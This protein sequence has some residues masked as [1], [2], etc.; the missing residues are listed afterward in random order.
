MSKPSA[1]AALK[2]LT[3]A[4]IDQSQLSAIFSAVNE[5][6]DRSAAIVWAAMVDDAL[7]AAIKRKMRPLSSTDED[8]LFDGQ[9]ALST[10]SS[11]I[12]VAYALCAIGQEQ[13]NGLERIRDIRNA[14]AH[15]PYISFKTKQIFD[16]A[17]LL[18][19]Y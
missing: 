1:V 17:M 3:R 7:K 2:T 10:F 16:V 9:G 6:D 4:P 12:I 13:R 14:F 11:K 19:H 15:H 18:H 8:K 5:G